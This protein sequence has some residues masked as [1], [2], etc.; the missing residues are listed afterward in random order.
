MLNRLLHRDLL[1]PSHN[2]NLHLHHTVTYG[3]DQSN[4]DTTGNTQSDPS[5]SET[6][7]ASFFA[8]DPSVKFAAK[9]PT[10]HRDITVKEF[11][12]KKLRWVTLGGQYNWTAKRYPTETP[13][14]F[15]ADIGRLVRQLFSD[16]DPQAAILN[17]YAPGDTLSVHRD[18]SEECDQALVSISIGCDAIFIVGNED[19]S[20]VAA[21][22]LRSGDAI[23]MTGDSRFAWH[24]VPKVLPN[25]CPTWLQDWP[26]SGPETSTFEIW[27]GWMA[28]KRINLNVRQMTA[29]S[30]G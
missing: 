9:D 13:P 17:L 23:C 8:M 19:G 4:F 2:T 6:N 27:R 7:H 5:G 30:Y 21:L 26:V 3:L 20:S 12:D 24:G 29:P 22:R 11:L 18:V 25:T 15:P 28:N 14:P 16:I 1:N 10:V